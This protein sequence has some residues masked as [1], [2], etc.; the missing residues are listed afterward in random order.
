MPPYPCVFITVLAA[1]LRRVVVRVD[2]SV[3]GNVSRVT[4]TAARVRHEDA[5][6]LVLDAG[7]G[8]AAAAAA[9]LVVDV[10]VAEAELEG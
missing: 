8:L 9:Q 3:R 1:V 7:S 5:L 6:L 2:V 4:V 10:G